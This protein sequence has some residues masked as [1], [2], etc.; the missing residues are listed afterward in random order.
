MVKLCKSL[1]WQKGEKADAR[2]RATRK[3]RGGKSNGK[4]TKQQTHYRMGGTRH[5]MKQR[6]MLCV[7]ASGCVP[8]RLPYCVCCSIAKVWNLPV[9]R[10]VMHTSNL[11]TDFVAI[12]LT[13]AL[14]AVQKSQ[15]GSQEERRFLPPSEK[16]PPFAF[17]R[18]LHRLCKLPMALLI[19]P[20]VKAKAVRSNRL[21][22]AFLVSC[23]SFFMQRSWWRRRRSTVDQML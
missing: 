16:R 2:E 19:S 8:N 17:K 11:H 7:C 15:N 14:Q 20:G 9:P 5:G 21:M 18:S 23:L 22:N 3:G 13:I 10:I 1:R 12:W 6:G 4:T